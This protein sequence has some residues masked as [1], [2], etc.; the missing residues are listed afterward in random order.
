[1]IPQP[2]EITF[3]NIEDYHVKTLSNGAKLYLLSR[4]SQEV[5]QIDV[6]TN[7]GVLYADKG[8]VAGAVAALS[9]EGSRSFTSQAIS[10]KLDFYGAYL[11]A[12][13][14]NYYSISSLLCI[15]KHLEKVLPCLEESVKYAVFPQVELDIYRG[16]LRQ[17]M[18]VNMQTPAYQANT[19]LREMIFE[20]NSRFARKATF[21]ALEGLNIDDILS[22]YNRYYTPDNIRIFVTGKPTEDNLQAIREAFS[23]DWCARYSVPERDFAVYRKEIL[24]ERVEMKDATQMSIAM[25][26][27][28][29]TFDH[30][31]NLAF[32]VLNCVLGGYFGSRLMTNIREKKGLTYGI[33]SGI[34][35]T[36]RMGIHIIS[37]DVNREN[38]EKAL[39]EIHN[40]LK[41]LQDEP[42]S[43]EELY[44]VKNYMRGEIVRQFDN[45]FMSSDAL[46]PL[47]L[48]D[49]NAQYFNELWQMIDAITPQ[50]LQTMAQKY[51]DFDKYHC[52]VAG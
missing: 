48:A 14:T 7:G 50:E 10:E 21:E 19:R 46:I 32:K 31:D 20:D 24:N 52:V 25:G 35:N 45:V 23:V 26:R 33:H 36:S 18:S 11:S 49:R 12:R 6:C 1:M 8:M 17:E 13:S 2:K 38:A 39:T 28:L 44:S 43:D 16:K 5:V 34:I 37:S 29:F 51:F 22:F 47:I 42:V 3:P 30:E 4:G 41:K 27:E 15:S 40:E 9:T